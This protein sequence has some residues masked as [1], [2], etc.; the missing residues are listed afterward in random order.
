[1]SGHHNAARLSERRDESPRS[2][3][4]FVVRHVHADASYTVAL[5]RERCEGPSRRAA[6]KRDEPG[7]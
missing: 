3:I 7:F 4:V 6:D 1:M 5:L 2:G